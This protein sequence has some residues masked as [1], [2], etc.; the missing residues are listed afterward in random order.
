MTD[1]ADGGILRGVELA[2]T[3]DGLLAILLDIEEPIHGDI[4]DIYARV[5]ALGILLRSTQ[6]LEGCGWFQ[7]TLQEC[8]SVLNLLCETVKTRRVASAIGQISE[9]ADFQ[10]TLSLALASSTRYVLH[11]IQDSLLDN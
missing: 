11:M 8:T 7:T 9:L 10:N 6:R 3:C 1:R 5:E 2:Q 4:K